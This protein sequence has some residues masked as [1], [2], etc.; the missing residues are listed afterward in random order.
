MQGYLFDENAFFGNI[1]NKNIR[2]L[3]IGRRAL[4]ALGIPV[5]TSDYDFWIHIDDIEGFNRVA[6]QFD[7]VPNRSAIE[8][9]AAG[10]YVLENDEH[11]DVVVARSKSTVHGD[12]VEFDDVWSRRIRFEIEDGK[13]IWIPTIE[14]LIRTKLF[15]ARAKDLDDIQLLEALQEKS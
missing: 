7:L 12:R 6:A 4:I 11:I 14:D 2:A 13:A 10:R 9:R 5:L 3:L 1:F 15:A 8:A